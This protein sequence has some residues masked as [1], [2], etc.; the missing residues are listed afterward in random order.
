MRMIP[1]ISFGIRIETKAM[2]IIARAHF[3]QL[4]IVHPYGVFTFSMSIAVIREVDSWSI[5]TST[6]VFSAGASCRFQFQEFLNFM[7]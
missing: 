4:K 5:V 7:C 3:S 2:V 1:L 6:S